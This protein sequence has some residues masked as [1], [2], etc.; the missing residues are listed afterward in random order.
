DI[1]AGATMCFDQKLANVE[2]LG[3]PAQGAVEGGDSEDRHGPRDEHGHPAQGAADRD[4]DDDQDVEDRRLG[5]VAQEQ[6]RA[7]HDRVPEAQVAVDDEEHPEHRERAD[8][9]RADSGECEQPVRY[10]DDEPVEKHLADV[11]ELEEVADRYGPRVMG[12]ERGVDE[13]CLGK[14]REHDHDEY[15]DE[16]AEE[17]EAAEREYHPLAPSACAECGQ[18]DHT[19]HQRADED[20]GGAP[21]EHPDEERADVLREEVPATLEGINPG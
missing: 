13:A 5:E 7:A 3:H 14:H 17:A 8:D 18:E 9:D 16:D 6:L 1:S 10:P 15:E 19:E 2:V 12:F 20:E 4:G 11:A 21:Q